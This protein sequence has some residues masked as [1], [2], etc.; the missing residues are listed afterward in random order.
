MIS[1]LSLFSFSVIPK[2]WEQILKKLEIDSFDGIEKFRDVLNYMGY[3]TSQSVAKLQR[4]KEIDRFEIELTKLGGNTSFRQKF[5][6]I[7][8]DLCHGD[9]LVLKEIASA[10]ASLNNS[11]KHDVDSIQEQVYERCKKVSQ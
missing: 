11:D 2:F 6:S 4:Q 3:K 7:K 9:I 8:S 1:G 5:P 10:A